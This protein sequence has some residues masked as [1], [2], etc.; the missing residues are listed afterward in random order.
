ME[1]QEKAGPPSI[2]ETF[3][4]RMTRV[5]EA[6]MALGDKA[7]GASHFDHAN[8]AYQAAGNTA[9]AARTIDTQMDA[10]DSQT[11][12]QQFQLQMMRRQA[13]PFSGVMGAGD[14]EGSM[15]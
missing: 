1:D 9:A 5:F 4:E 7:T 10:Q 2:K 3:A 8:I 6:Q 12:T 14:F 13:R 15:Q 11:K